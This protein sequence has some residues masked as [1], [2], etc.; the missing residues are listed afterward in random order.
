MIRELIDLLFPA[1]CASCDE[2]GSGLCQL[3]APLQD[4]VFH[5]DL[6]SLRVRGLGQ[7][8]GAYRRAVLALKDGRRDVATA[9]ASRL[10]RLEIGGSLLVPV[11]TTSARKRIR[12][13]DNVEELA[14][15]AALQS[16]G[17][18]LPA[19]RR[20]GRDAQRGRARDARLAARGRFACDATFSPSTK[21]VLVDDV[22][23]TGSTLEDCAAAVRAAGGVVEEAVVVALA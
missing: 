14:R 8:C 7:Y 10:A 12:G 11:T 18:F 6:D 13:M 1:Q 9:L 15:L 20:T 22:C 5:R 4:P 17:R 19:L 23:T 21:I 3:C 2:A 16:G